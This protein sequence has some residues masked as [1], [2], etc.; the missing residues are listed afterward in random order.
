VVHSP[1]LQGCSTL[2]S[3]S[4][5]DFVLEAT[6]LKPEHRSSLPALCYIFSPGNRLE[7]GPAGNTCSKALSK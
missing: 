7:A 4:A 3:Q 1:P 5:E 2:A 6:P